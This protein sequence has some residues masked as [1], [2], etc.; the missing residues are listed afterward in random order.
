VAR[1]FLK[2]TVLCSGE[3]MEKG[4]MA[5]RKWAVNS[6]DGRHGMREGADFEGESGDKI[7]SVA[8]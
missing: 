6:D 1:R 8:C 2:P 4:S 7:Q 5:S 3:Q